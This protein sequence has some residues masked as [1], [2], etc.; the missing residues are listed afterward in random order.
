MS[1]TLLTDD[2]HLRHCFHSNCLEAWRENSRSNKTKCPTCRT[3]TSRWYRL[4]FDVA[5]SDDYTSS[6]PHKSA[7]LAEA[8]EDEDDEE[9]KS[10][11]Q[12][13]SEMRMLLWDKREALQKVTQLA[14]E[15]AARITKLNDLCQSREDDLVAVEAERNELSRLDEGKTVEINRLKSKLESVGKQHNRTLAD[16]QRSVFAICNSTTALDGWYS[17]VEQSKARAARANLER[18]NH[19]SDVTEEI[20]KAKKEC[21]RLQL[22]VDSSS[23]QVERLE[24]ANAGYKEDLAKRNVKPLT[25]FNLISD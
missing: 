15:Q 11:E 6:S 23:S 18:N 16:L 21:D 12:L 9:S 19:I 5:G 22:Q 13:L 25:T 10:P 4:F 17:K 3:S 24:M 1:C 7:V 20:T 8:T 2:L 14:N